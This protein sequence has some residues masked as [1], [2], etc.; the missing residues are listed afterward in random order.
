MSEVRSGKTGGWDGR[1]QERGKL[2]LFDEGPLDS[3][4]RFVLDFC[5]VT[6][7]ASGVEGD[8]TFR[9]PILLVVGVRSGRTWAV[10][11]PLLGVVGSPT[12]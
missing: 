4:R 11:F 9:P 6:P 5:G 2:V 7:A 1:R 3:G 8:L 10:S 12:S